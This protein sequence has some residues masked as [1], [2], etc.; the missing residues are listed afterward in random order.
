MIGLNSDHVFFLRG[1]EAL[2]E[3]FLR[4]QIGLRPLPTP[5]NLFGTDAIL[6]TVKIHE[7]KK[8]DVH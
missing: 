1:G 2:P 7:Y 6:S 4:K 8:N 5:L 3:A